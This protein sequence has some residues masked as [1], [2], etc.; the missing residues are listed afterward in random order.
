[1]PGDGLLPALPGDLAIRNNNLFYNTAYF[2]EGINLL[3]GGIVIADPE[4]GGRSRT[5]FISGKIEFGKF[6]DFLMST[7]AFE[8]LLHQV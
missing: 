6:A 1:M 4:G 5:G 3:H 2:F 7:L 8:L